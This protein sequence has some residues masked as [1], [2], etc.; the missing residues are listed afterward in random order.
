MFERWESALVTEEGVELNRELMLHLACPRCG[1]RVAVQGERVCCEGGSCGSIYPIVNGVPVMIDD[2]RSLF[3]VS[4]FLDPGVTWQKPFRN[5]WTRL[6]HR[7]TP[8]VYSD[9]ASSRVL[10]QLSMDCRNK[11]GARDAVVLVIGVGPR[12]DSLPELRAEGIQLVKTDVSHGVDVDV[13]CD[14]HQLALGD[15]SV[16]A[17]VIMN[18]LE[19][20]LDPHECV[21]EIHRVLRPDGLVYAQ[22]PFIQQVHGGPYDFT[23][24]TP[25][26]H[27]WLFRGFDEIEAGVQS[28]PGMALAWST[29]YWGRSLM[30]TRM[31][32]RA[33]LIGASFLTFWLRFVDAIISMK[34]GSYDAAAEVFF[35]G[36]RSETELQ[37]RDLLVQFRGAAN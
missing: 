34:P 26:G 22:T 24:F 20:V 8:S 13:I 35:Y 3:R 27:R 37:P 2:E 1:S 29:I 10:T 33:W 25:L 16:D 9:L 21:A 4:D 11:L 19:H 15:G 32:R 17:V 5:R 7:I 14:A 18:V 23:R 36:R 12:S 30:D 28:G 6:A 31:W